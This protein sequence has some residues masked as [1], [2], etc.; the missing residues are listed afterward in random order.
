[1]CEESISCLYPSAFSISVFVRVRDRGR[2]RERW[3]HMWERFIS[4]LQL[5]L[6]HGKKSESESLV[7]R[8]LNNTLE[9]SHR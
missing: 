7:L 6:L 9:P 3:D 5:V 4:A 8:E 1:M 2:E